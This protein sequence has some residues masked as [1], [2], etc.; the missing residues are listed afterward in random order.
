[1]HEAF[2]LILYGMNTKIAKINSTQ[3]FSALQYK[4]ESDGH[5]QANNKYS[6]PYLKSNFLIR[7]DLTVDLCT[8]QDV[9]SNIQKALNFCLLLVATK[10]LPLNY[11]FL[12]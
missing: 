8:N 12:M 6:S 1:M 7:P 5:P 3:T 9:L 2:P 11:L 4:T 10:R